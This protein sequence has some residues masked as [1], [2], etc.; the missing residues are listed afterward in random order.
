M[1]KELENKLS[2]LAKLNK[3]LDELH[4]GGVFDSKGLDDGMSLLAGVFGFKELEKIINNEE[5]KYDAELAFLKKTDNE[6]EILVD[7]NGGR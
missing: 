4:K 7:T 5:G 1:D 2:C 6:F 3:I